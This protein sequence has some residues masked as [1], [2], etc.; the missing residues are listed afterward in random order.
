MI[1]KLLKDLEAKRQTIDKDR[2]NRWKRDEVTVELFND[3][4]MWMID[5][6]NDDA[7]SNS[8]ESVAFVHQRAGVKSAIQSVVD[9]VP[10]HVQI[11]EQEQEQGN[12]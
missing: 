2:F 9:W 6:L 4:Q 3:I 5:R 12:E 8:D 1:D 7:P 11:Q 10:Y